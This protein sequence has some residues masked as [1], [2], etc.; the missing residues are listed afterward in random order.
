ME[1]Q[2]VLIV[3]PQLVRLDL[4]SALDERGHNLHSVLEDVLAHGQVLVPDRVV[5]LDP[6]DLSAETYTRTWA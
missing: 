1:V 4:E 3:D 2:L 5:Y 6:S